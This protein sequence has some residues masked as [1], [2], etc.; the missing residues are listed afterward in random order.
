MNCFPQLGKTSY[1]AESPGLNIQIYLWIWECGITESKDSNILMA[2]EIVKAL[3][4]NFLVIQWLGLQAFTAKDVGST[5]GWGTTILKAIQCSQRKKKCI[6]ACYKPFST[7]LLLLLFTAIFN[8]IEE[9]VTYKTHMYPYIFTY[10][11]ILTGIR[12]FFVWI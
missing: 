7:V 11:V 10:I 4:G 6:F 8:Q 12:H 3:L 2:N 1:L 9:K 5:P